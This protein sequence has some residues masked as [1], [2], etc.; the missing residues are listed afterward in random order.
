ML[1]QIRPALLLLGAF[2]VVTG[3]GYPLAITGIAQAVM[4]GPANGSLLERDG[5]VVGSTLIGQAF[6]EDRYFHPRPSA[7]SGPDPADPTKTT[8]VPYNAAASSGSN[9]GPTNKNL[10][11]RIAEGVAAWRNAGAASLPADAVTTSASG[12]DPHVSVETA[13]L[14]VERVAAARDVTPA[15]MREL[16]LAQ[17]EGRTLGFLGEPRVNVLQLNLALD[18]LRP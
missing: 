15:S 4:R 14:Q 5:V 10:I 2:I 18:A 1:E 16:V 8:S 7:T 11:A 6:T 17:V 3:L 12:L 13:L 9:L